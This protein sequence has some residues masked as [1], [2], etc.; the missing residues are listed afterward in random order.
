MSKHTPG[1]W[2]WFGSTRTSMYLATTHSGR[3]Y[4]M[5]F[6]RKGMSGAEPT[7]QIDSVMVPASELA[8]YEVNREATSAKD[9]S[10]YRHDIVGF[11]SADARLIAAAPEL[12]EALA[13]MLDF[14]GGYECPEV[15]EAIRVMQT[16]GEDR[17]SMQAQMDAD[18]TG[19]QP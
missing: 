12:K 8:I 2:A 10:V 6:K 4:V 3:R 16:I 7:F 9:P 1:P 19:V 14:W 13:K 11:R 5:G 18:K 15:D 17:W